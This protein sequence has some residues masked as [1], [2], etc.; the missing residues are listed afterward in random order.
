VNEPGPLLRPIR[1]AD[2]SFSLY[3]AAFGEGFHCADGALA[4]SIDTFVAPAELERFPH[5]ARL[6]VLEV[7]VGTGTNTA[8]LIEACAT[9]GL[10]LDWWGLELERQPLALALADASFRGQ[11]PAAVLEQLAELAASGRLLWGDARQCLAALEA[12]LA[13]RCDL[14]L[15][16]AFSPRRCPQ[17]WSQEFLERLAR[18]L[19]PSG[20]LLTYCSA[21]AVRGSLERAGL[22]LAAIQ[23]RERAGGSWS[24]G[25]VAS[26]GPLPPSALLRPLGPMEREHLACRAGAPYRDPVGNA[27]AA[28]ILATRER[29]QALSSA[30]T[31]SAWQRRWGLGLR[32]R[33][34]P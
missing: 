26:P 7:A 17:L 34:Q 27:D 8:T 10:S 30:E 9:A 11:W 6:T 1:T 3:S 14:V 4:E 20:R 31:S 29:A 23:Q 2:G 15:I 19:A 12:P 33:R 22:Q 21:A 13:G 5:G 32:R 28:W 16:D 24:G 18:L 25:T